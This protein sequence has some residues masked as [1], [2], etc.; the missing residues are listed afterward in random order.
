MSDSYPYTPRQIAGEF[1]SLSRDLGHRWELINQYNQWLSGGRA[2]TG[3]E[4]EPTFWD[5][6]TNQLR[7]AKVLGVTPVDKSPKF[8]RR[9]FL[10]SFCNPYHVVLWGYPV[11]NP[12]LLSSPS[13]RVLW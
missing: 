1:L 5:E 2:D 4:E 11:T 13:R 8:H 10:V 3:E 12:L 7:S 9:E 6:S